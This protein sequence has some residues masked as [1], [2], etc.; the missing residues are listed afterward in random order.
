MTCLIRLT[1]EYFDLP[2]TF[3]STPPSLYRQ[4]NRCPEVAEIK[5]AIETGTLP[6]ATVRR[7][8]EDLLGRLRK[9]ERFP[10][11]SAMAALAVVLEDRFTPFAE[12]Y[13][14]TLASLNLAEMSQSIS[15]AKLCLARRGIGLG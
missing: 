11:D 2:L 3:Y 6:E 13:L 7:F 5:S 8:V 10:Y 12:E 1:Q 15:V 9:G 4:L 14:S